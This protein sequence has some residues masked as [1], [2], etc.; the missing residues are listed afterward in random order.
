VT[1]TDLAKG[2]ITPRTCPTHKVFNR[3]RTHICQGERQWGGVNGAAGS[4][5]NK[6]K[7]GKNTGCDMGARQKVSSTNQYWYTLL[8]YEQ[9]SNSGANQRALVLAHG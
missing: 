6:K 7:E 4:K 1:L 8:S 3:P 9:I 5:A 2:P